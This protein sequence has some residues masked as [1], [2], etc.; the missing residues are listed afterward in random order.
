MPIVSLVLM[1]VLVLG[2]LV[3]LW[4]SRSTLSRLQNEYAQ[5]RAQEGILTEKVRQRTERIEEL[6]QEV[7]DSAEKLDDLREENTEL[8]TEC[9][10]LRTSIN[11]ERQSSDEKLA[12]LKKMREQLKTDF[13]N[14]SNRIFEEKGKKFSKNNSE[15]LNEILTPM[16][17]QLGDFR[18]RVDEIHRNDNKERGSLL[19][20]VQ[21]LKKLNQQ[22]SEDAVNLTRALK[23]ES[24][25]MGDW[26]EML[27]ERI[28]ESSGLR[29]GSEY[30]LQFSGAGKGGERL[31]P[32]AVVHLPEEKDVVV[33]AKVSLKAYEQYA[34]AEDPELREGALKDLLSSIRNHIKGLSAKQYED[35]DGVKS[36]DFVLMFIPIEPAFLVAM[37]EDP[38]LYQKAFDDSIMLVSPSTLM[39]TLRIIEN[40][41]RTD[42][43][44]RNADKIAERGGLLYDKFVQFV[45][46]LDEIER[47]IQ[48]ASEAYDKAHKRL[49]SGKGNLVRQAEMLSELG[50]KG[51]KNIPKKL[52]GGESLE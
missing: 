52:R 8:K 19:N 49:S 36:L 15:R 32:D 46:A 23:G 1:I 45:E 10:E 24:K 13:E 41:W 26:G 3:A 38:E 42:R 28:L 44:N 50:A 39:L 31:R 37:A 29:A 22:I 48:K 30:E 16:R 6:K 33:D 27:L 25:T 12:D 21:N 7:T 34:S 11:K 4:H 18:K 43:Q 40:I 20:E 14:L 17:E 35:M 5:S 2:L 47:H 51:K 9:S